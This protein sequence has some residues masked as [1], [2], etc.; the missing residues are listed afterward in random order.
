MEHADVRMFISAHASAMNSVV[1]EKLASKAKGNLA[2]EI[3]CT[4]NKLKSNRFPGSI[5]LK[6]QIHYP[7]SHAQSPRQI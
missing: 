6:L 3:T 4:L 5:G 2:S 7:L 1:G